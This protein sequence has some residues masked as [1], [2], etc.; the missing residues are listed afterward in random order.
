MG[1]R[2][3]VTIFFLKHDRA[4]VAKVLEAESFSREAEWVNEGEYCDEDYDFAM[5]ENDFGITFNELNWGGEALLRTLDEHRIPYYG[6][7]S[8]GDS[9]GACVFANTQGVYGSSAANSAEGEPYIRALN[10]DG[11]TIADPKSLATATEY[12]DTQAKITELGMAV[13]RLPGKTF[14]VVDHQEK[15]YV[16]FSC[17]SANGVF[18]IFAEAFKSG[19]SI[20]T[21]VETVPEGYKDVT[22]DMIDVATDVKFLLDILFEEKDKTIHDFLVAKKVKQRIIGEQDGHQG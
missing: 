16:D 7:H 14:F 13:A 5:Y 10:V 11:K 17:L 18:Y 1:D 2:C 12:F 3:R 20:D 21:F 9:Y 6:D 15:K 8:P 4:L 19:M 22:I